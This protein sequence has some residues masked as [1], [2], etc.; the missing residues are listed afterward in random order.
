MEDLS[1]PQPKITWQK[2]LFWIGLIIFIVTI[3][4]ICSFSFLGIHNEAPSPS[5]IFTH[6]VS[7]VPSMTDQESHILTVSLYGESGHCTVNVQLDITNFDMSPSENI[8]QASVDADQTTQV[9]WVLSP[10]SQGTFSYAVSFPGSQTLGVDESTVEV[11]NDVGF[12]AW[13]TSV[14]AP[15]AVAV[16]GPLLTV[17]YWID[18]YSEW[19]KKRKGKQKASVA[20][21]RKR[22]KRR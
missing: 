18:K 7:F 21:K 2:R 17:P 1:P 9:V 16:L 3:L 11:T 19:I 15:A 14:L 8:Q 10:K 20:K 12:P 22:V 6:K 4:V 5:C 13:I